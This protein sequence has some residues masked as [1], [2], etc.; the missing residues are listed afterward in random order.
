MVVL[1]WKTAL[2]KGVDHMI[3]RTTFAGVIWC[4]VVKS[5]RQ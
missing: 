5:L 3:F 2:I 1:R 4:H